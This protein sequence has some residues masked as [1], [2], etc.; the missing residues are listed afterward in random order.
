M[1]NA[2]L[3]DIVGA[4]LSS[5][6]VS[7]LLGIVVA[8]LV[9]VTPW[10]RTRRVPAA[11]LTGDG[12]LALAARHTPERRLLA[13]GALAVLAT[14][15]TVEVLARHVLTLSGQVSWWRYAAPVFSAAAVLA[16]LALLITIRRVRGTTRPVVTGARR[17][18]LSFRPRVGLPAAG[19]SLLAL[20]LTTIA[21]G[22]ASSNIHGGPFVFLEIPAPNT[23]VDPIRVWFFGW[24]YGI[25]VLIC[26]ALLAV[27]A[28]WALTA[29]ATRPFLRAE[30][31]PAE[32]HER[33]RIA[34]GIAQIATG[35][36]LLTLATA[37]RFIGDAGRIGPLTI[38]D[39]GTFETVWRYADIAGAAGAAAP[40]LEVVAVAL[41]VLSALSMRSSAP[42]GR[43]GG[44]AVSPL[45]TEGAR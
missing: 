40:V 26:C 34:A 15:V 22:C 20:V 31:V 9:S 3:P 32:H 27:S 16:V 23:D 28:V 35:G 19:L 36:V 45:Q 4:I 8:A 18:W 7:L 33:A 12:A 14:G 42:G 29:N 41:L 24:A 37:W 10:W 30:T 17:T 6:A 1:P 44:S 5:P 25:A 11:R 39:A 2:T 43:A 21:A 13:V 38:E